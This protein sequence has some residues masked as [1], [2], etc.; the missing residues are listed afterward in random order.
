M[1][2]FRKIS[3]IIVSAAIIMSIL[4]MTAV[5]N[6]GAAIGDKANPSGAYLKFTVDVNKPEDQTLAYNFLDFKQIA[7]TVAEGDVIEY[8]VWFNV[9]EKGWGHVDANGVTNI[10]SNN[11]RDVAGLADADGTGMHTGQD[12]SGYGYNQWYHRVIEL[13]SEELVGQTIDWFQIACH[14]ESGELAYQG[15]VMYDNIVITNGGQEKLVI[16]RDDGD[17]DGTV[18]QSHQ[19]DCV[20]VLEKLAFTDEDMAAFKAAEE[21]AAAAAASSSDCF[22]LASMLACSRLASLL[23]SASALDASLDASSAILASSA[24]LNACISASVK[25]RHSIV[26][27]SH[28]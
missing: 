12:L 15:I 2:P 11:L 10:G 13:A 20:A 23:A 25:T 16:F 21:A 1:K 5:L 14:P 6:A 9:E 28:P 4:S 26:P 19:K 17:W 27:L 7:Y 22:T 3:A 18:R 8:D 24:S